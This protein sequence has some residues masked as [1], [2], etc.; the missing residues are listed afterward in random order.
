MFEYEDLIKNYAT[1]PFKENGPQLTCICPFHD[2]HNPSLDFNMEKGV[3]YCHSCNASGNITSFLAKVTGKDK[4]EIWKMLNPMPPYTLE[5]YA[6]EKKLPIS[7]LKEWG[8]ADS[9][10][11]LMI[12]YYDENSKVIATKYR[13]AP[14]SKQRFTWKKG[15]KT[16][17]YGLWRLLPFKDDYIVIAEG[18]SDTHTLW[19][20]D[21]QTVGVPGAT[22]FK[23]SYKDVFKRFKKV[24]ALSDEDEAGIKFVSDIAN[25]L[26]PQV[27]QKI[28]CSA[29]GAKD[30]SELHLQGKFNFEKLLATAE[31]IPLRLPD[32][33]EKELSSN[34]KPCKKELYE[35]AEELADD[36]H[37]KFYG[38]ILYIYQDGVYVPDDGHIEEEIYAIDKTLTQHS[39]TEISNYLKIIGRLRKVITHDN[40]I[41]FQNGFLDIDTKQLIPHDPNI[42]C[43]NQI[44]CNY[45]ENAPKN[46]F[47][48]KFL[49]DITSGITTRKTAILQIIGY[50]M[51]TSVELQKAF[52][53]LGKTAGN[54]KSTLL[55]VIDE[56]I[57]DSNIS[58]ITL[59]S[60]Q[61]DKFSSSSLTNK[62]LNMVAELPRNHLKTIEVFKSLVTGDKMAAE[63]KYKDSFTIKPYAKNLFTANELPRVDDKS[64][65]YFRRLNILIFD[66]KFTAKEVDAFDFKKLITQEAL[67]YLACISI[68]AYMELLSSGTRLF[69]N[70]EESQKEVEKYR[71][72]NN[73]VL[74][75]LDSDE[76]KDMIIT[77]Q[78][79]YRPELYSKYKLYCADCNYKPLSR[80]K[81]Y[82]E[83]RETGLFDEKLKD[84][85]PQFK[86]RNNVISFDRDNLS[87]F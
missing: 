63:K 34:T 32:E 44:N 26:H 41:N 55:K 39:R 30:P 1:G 5:Q 45:N 70:E 12:P 73:S 43:V 82:D 48:D 18:E 8:L 69:A 80:N 72:E 10:N 2:D 60:L 67:E 77:G 65:G 40:L 24:Y 17:L 51:T 71:K 36:K 79:I 61:Q 15:S 31:D 4:K 42:F 56:L 27:V 76:I 3:Y 52:I 85:Y 58:H 21:I 9:D 23:K 83:I 62:L 81:F 29:L 59:Q 14:D 47:I 35:V 20:Y 86:R 46:E 7:E 33:L 28:N 13:H 84:G 78:S 6:E 19:H 54:G 64:D 25:I 11:D 50:C 57:G 87:A 38:N 37:I 16:N 22:N 75:F 74:S 68:K 49:D 66:K 53:F